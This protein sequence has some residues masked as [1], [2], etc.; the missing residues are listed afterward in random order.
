MAKS[1]VR[2]PEKGGGVQSLERA[3]A[4]LDAVAA[5]RD[6]IG[7]TEL[8]AQVG[9]NTS[10]AFHLIKTL[11]ALGFVVQEAETKRYRIGSHVFA[12]AAGA[13]NEATLLTLAMPVLEALSEETGE[14]AHLAVRTRGEIA[15]VARTEATGMLQMSERVGIMRPAHATAIGKVLLAYMPERQRAELVAGLELR[16]FTEATITDRCRLSTELETVLHEGIAHDRCEFD[17]DVRCI[18]MPVLDFSGRCVAAIGISGPIWRMAQEDVAEKGA[19]LGRAADDLSSL[20]GY[21]KAD[22]AE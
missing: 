8:S 14:A 22:A 17:A 18:A 19:A 4:L 3:A 11:V 21:R 2:K 1:E 6:G 10:T 13:M 16:K 5:C 20:L 12:L 15:L 9:L 7:L